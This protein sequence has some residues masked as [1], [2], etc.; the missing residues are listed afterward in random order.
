MQFGQSK[1]VVA[2]FKVPSGSAAGAPCLTV[3]LKYQSRGSTATRSIT[4][5]LPAGAWDRDPAVSA[6]IA[7]QVEFGRA[8]ALPDTAH[9]L[10][11]RCMKRFGTSMS[12]TTA[13]PTRTRRACALASSTG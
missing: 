9:P 4:A 3:T 11:P 1:D 12:E 6:E 5:E 7:L 10:H 2:R 13:R 8:A